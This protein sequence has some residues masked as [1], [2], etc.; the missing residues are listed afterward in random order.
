M[1]EYREYVCPDCVE[2]TYLQQVVRENLVAEQCDYCGREEEAPIACHIDDLIE[3]ITAAVGEY[4]D[5]PVDELMWDGR[6]GG[7]QGTVLDAWEMLEDLGVSFSSW[8]LQEDVASH[9]FDK[10]FCDKD[11]ILLRPVERQIYGWSHFKEAVKHQRRYTFWTAMDNEEDAGHPDYLPT[12]Y[13]LREIA[14]VINTVRNVR[15][16]PENTGF[17]R[18]RI[19][20]VDSPL[21]LAADFAAPP[22]DLAKV[23]NRMSPA[24]VSMFY[25]ATDFATAV[26]ETYEPGRGENKAAFG[27]QF[28]TCRAMRMLDLVNLP[29]APSIFDVGRREL[30]DALGFMRQFRDDLTLPISRDGR[31]HIEYVPTQVFT[32]FV[33]YEL[34][35]DGVRG[36]DGILYPSS[37]NSAECCVI[38]ADHADCLDHDEPFLRLRQQSLRFDPASLRIEPQQE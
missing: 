37:R 10:S 7:Y 26:V 16:V 19:H 11:Y 27:A 8:E 28:M 35:L 4:Y 34:E 20:D 18:V 24:G 14:W 15:L 32:E 33:L 30:R 6:E 5:D 2:E 22:L 17:W 1:P 36:F 3:A 13:M 25:G 29:T 31:E 12:A 9:Y 23:S 38:F 21:R